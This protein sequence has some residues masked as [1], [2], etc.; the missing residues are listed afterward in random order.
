[1]WWKEKTENETGMKKRPKKKQYNISHSF[2]KRLKKKG[3]EGREKA[4]GKI[5]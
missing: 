3:K 5:F 4:K 2:L 1:M